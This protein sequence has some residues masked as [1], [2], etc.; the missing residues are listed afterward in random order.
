MRERINIAKQGIIFSRAVDH[1]PGF[2]DK[3]AGEVWMDSH[4]TT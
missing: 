3:K 4:R 1:E 2:A